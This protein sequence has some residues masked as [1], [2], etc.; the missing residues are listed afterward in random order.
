MFKVVEGN[1]I[2]MA[3]NREFDVL[4]HEC[5]CFCEMTG[6]SKELAKTFPKIAEVDRKTEVGDVY[7]MGSYTHVY[8]K[9]IGLTIVNLYTK[10]TPSSV[11]EYTA[12]GIG[13]RNLVQLLDSDLIVGMPLM[14][15]RENYSVDPQATKI[16]KQEL[17]IFDLKVVKNR[18]TYDNKRR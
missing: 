18:I 14:G 1:I 12:L 10:Y 11:F 6:L 3:L 5:N 16:I 4:I 2:E 13:L 7:K 9:E 15:F 8:I 17:D